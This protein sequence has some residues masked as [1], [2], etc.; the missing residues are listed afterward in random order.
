VVRTP[1]V[2]AA[3]VA[4]LAVSTVGGRSWAVATTY[5]AVRVWPVGEPPDSGVLVRV[6]SRMSLDAAVL[7]GRRGEEVLVGLTPMDRMSR[8]RL[9]T[10][11]LMGT[12]DSLHPLWWASDSRWG[13][14][15]AVADHDGASLVVTAV[16]DRSLRAWDP[17]T[18]AQVGE[19]W[20]GHRDKI[21]G[22]V[23][24]ML[25]DGTPLVLSG[26]LSGEVRRWDARTGRDHGPPVRLPDCVPA[27]LAVA[28]LPDGRAMVC[29]AGTDGTVH[30]FE[31]ATGR[32]LGPAIDL[33]RSSDGDVGWYRPTRLACVA[34]AEVAVVLTTVD[35]RTVDVRDL[36]DGRVL[37]RV[38]TGHGIAAMAAASLDDGTPVV[39]V[40]DH[41]G[42]LRGFRAVAGTRLGAPTRPFDRPLYNV[43]PVSGPTGDVVLAARLT[44]GSCRFDAATGQPIDDPADPLPAFGTLCGVVAVPGRGPM[45]VTADETAIYRVDLTTGTQCEP[46][47]V[48]EDND[49]WYGVTVVA[50]PD[51][52]VIA[53]GR[54]DGKV[55]RWDAATGDPLPALTGHP[56][57]VKAVTGA[58]AA[59]GAPMIVSVSEAGDVRRWHAGT[60]E[61]IG[62]PLAAPEFD[63]G[64]LVVVHHGDGRQVLICATRFSGT[65]YQ[66][67]P[68]TGQPTGPTFTLDSWAEL[69]AAYVS[70]DGVPFAVLAILDRN[71][72][73]VRVERWRL[74]TARKVDELPATTRAVFVHAGAARMVL[75]N[76]DGSLTVTDLPSG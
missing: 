34:A 7:A 29:V 47:P 32:P 48:D 3:A 75:A 43:L 76:E 23:S 38:D 6:G 12:D 35:G 74:D 20:R 17:L 46:G 15:V 68:V 31:A 53:G 30:R 50:L 67:D 45:L 66:W 9:P 71:Y 11:E 8:W 10:G 36:A 61:P 64:E 49:G 33:G 27:E 65:V 39:L 59:D 16:G 56:T 24:V 37:G 41:G 58:T 72:D 21:V 62:T 42:Y 1:P 22:V 63:N 40:A 28:R 52:V 4:A 2:G 60:G 19:A 18:G 44:G 57:I 73:T 13:S 5:D 25:A 54:D 51:R 26:D 55:Y 70:P 69:T 14:P